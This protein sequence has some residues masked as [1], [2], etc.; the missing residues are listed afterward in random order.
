[1]ARKAIPER[2]PVS[3][4]FTGVVLQIAGAQALALTSPTEVQPIA[5][6]V[7]IIR[8]GIGYLGKPH[9]SLVP[10]LVALDY[11]DMLTGE[12]AWSFLLKRSNLYPRADVVGYRNDGQDDM[13]Q[14]KWLDLAQPVTV[15]VYAD[16]SA[17]MPIARPTVA[18]GDKAHFP[19]RLLEYLPH[20]ET[21]AEWQASL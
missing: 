8:Y 1:V 20:Y 10:G 21:V 15:L 11:G 7:L 2:T 19:P 3:D 6:G 4:I 12:E 9:L 5:A 14:I 16:N 13:I 18:I 17:T